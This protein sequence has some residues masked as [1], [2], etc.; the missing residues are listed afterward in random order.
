MKKVPFAFQSTVRRVYFDLLKR[1]VEEEGLTLNL[2]NYG[3]DVIISMGFLRPPAI[4]A[5]IDSHSSWGEPNDLTNEITPKGLNGRTYDGLKITIK[6]F[7]YRER[8]EKIADNM[9]R[10]LAEDVIIEEMY[11]N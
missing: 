4:V 7:R 2:E 9:R 5:T 6:N 1:F 3:E 8:I 10:H 11:D